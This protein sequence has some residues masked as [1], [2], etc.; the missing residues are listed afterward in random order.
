[1]IDNLIQRILKCKKALTTAAAGAFLAL[2]SFA[3]AGD[4]PKGFDI[5]Q[6]DSIVQQMDEKKKEIRLKAFMSEA[7]NL[8]DIVMNHNFAGFSAGMY[9]H[10]TDSIG[11]DFYVRG[12][13]GIDTI[14]P[15]KRA[16]LLSIVRNSS[17]KQPRLF[18]N[19]VGTFALDFKLGLDYGTFNEEEMYYRQSGEQWFGGTASYR[20]RGFKITIGGG[21]YWAA[22]NYQQLGGRVTPNDGVRSEM[23]KPG[24]YFVLAADFGKYAGFLDTSRYNLRVAVGIYGHRRDAEFLDSSTGEEKSARE[25]WTRVRNYAVFD[26]ELNDSYPVVTVGVRLELEHLYR[27]FHDGVRQDSLERN[28]KFQPHIS[29][30]WRGPENKKNNAMYQVTISPLYEY[31]DVFES[32]ELGRSI[33]KENL[34]GGHVKIGFLRSGGYYPAVVFTLGGKKSLNNSNWDLGGQLEFVFRL[35]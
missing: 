28:T 35:F 13:V 12:S 32:G 5:T 11:A 20:D 21:E 33:I 4:L 8:D 10:G 7:Y 15:K 17:E 3:Y 6:K 9:S 34:L 31:H 19:G 25:N 29:F 30:F 27:K 22:V 2:S 16:R 24:G 18:E 14:N 23:G 26:A 1:M